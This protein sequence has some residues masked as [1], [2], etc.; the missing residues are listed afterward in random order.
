MLTHASCPAFVRC[1]VCTAVCNTT[2]PTLVNGTWPSSCLPN[3]MQ[4]GGIRT[5]NSACVG[6]C[7]AGF[8]G[9]PIVRCT[10]V[11]WAA[12]EGGC[13]PNAVKSG[14]TQLLFAQAGTLPTAHHKHTSQP[15][16]D[17]SCVCPPNVHPVPAHSLLGA[18][19]QT[20]QC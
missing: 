3:A 15:D 7:D 11:G 4:I 19:T 16:D 14:S 10:N 18:A 13:I 2:L 20:D 5:N 1:R 8:Y 17:C 6:T 9:S 12:V